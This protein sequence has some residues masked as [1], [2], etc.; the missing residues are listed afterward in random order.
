MQRGSRK[1]VYR[2]AR[3]RA[4]TSQPREGV[5][6]QERPTQWWWWL[7]VVVVPAAD[8]YPITPD[9]NSRSRRADQLNHTHH[10]QHRTFVDI[11]AEGHKQSPRPANCDALE[12]S[13]EGR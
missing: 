12:P 3:L 11:N 13:H 1:Q 10:A 7:F 5:D 6:W 9:V 2:P 4:T 8:V